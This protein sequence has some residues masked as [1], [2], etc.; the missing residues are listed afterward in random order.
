MNR[1]FQVKTVSLLIMGFISL[2][3]FSNVVQAVTPIQIALFN[4]IQLA[5]SDKSVTGVRLNLI[6]GKNASLVGLDIGFINH[7][8]EKS[9]GIQH[10]FI[11]YNE[12]DFT[13]FQTNFISITKGEFTG[14]QE[15]FYNGA[16]KGT[17]FQYGFINRRHQ[18]G[19][20][21]VG[22]DQLCGNHG[23]NTNRLGEYHQAKRSVSRI[24]HSELV[25]V[26][27]KFIFGAPKKKPS[28]RRFFFK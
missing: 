3:L 16:G 4:P 23:R 24:P 6:Y 25:A 20:I 14:L 27:G 18:M 12:S 15:G 13:G 22:R 7:L 9:F 21:A 10:G 1:N 19:R 28:F 2:L 11:S 5:P 8:T 17:G 26:V